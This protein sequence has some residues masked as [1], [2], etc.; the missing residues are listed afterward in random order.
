MNGTGH[1][2]LPPETPLIIDPSDDFFA[3]TPAS[4]G[5]HRGS[6]T[7]INDLLSHTTV[8][9]G[10]S[11]QL[12]KRLSQTV[13]RLESER[14]TSKDELTRLNA[15]RDEARQEVVELMREVEA[16]RTG[17]ERIA[18]L[19]KEVQDLDARYQASLEMLGEK[20]ETVE[21]LRSDVSDLKRI[22]RETVDSMTR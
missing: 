2:M 18:S 8:P 17:D 12:V 10:P 16:K 20:S 4:P 15:Q 7:G 14:S 1:N 22:L 6:T 3:E 9:A 13:R 21:E 5:T 11:V 19:E